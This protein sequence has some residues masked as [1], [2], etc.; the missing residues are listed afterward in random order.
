MVAAAS[1]DATVG[2]PAVPFIVMRVAR[3][4]PAQVKRPDSEA[5]SPRSNQMAVTLHAVSAVDTA[6]QNLQ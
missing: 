1:S 4:R 2:A 6:Q 3:S 5:L